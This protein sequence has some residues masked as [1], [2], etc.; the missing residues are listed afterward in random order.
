MVR[1]VVVFVIKVVWIR[2]V[3]LCIILWLVSMVLWLIEFIE[4]FLLRI[5][6][7]GFVYI[8]ICL[9]FMIDVNVDCPIE[10]LTRA[11]VVWRTID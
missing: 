4:G 1:V 3:V 9:I 2:F 10:L 11:Y 7:F 5:V 8:V 6:R